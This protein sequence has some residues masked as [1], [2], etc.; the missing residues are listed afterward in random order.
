MVIES[1]LISSL[2]V[3]HGKEG[4]LVN[5]AIRVVV[6]NGV[7]GAIRLARVIDEARGTAHMHAVD[8]VRWRGVGGIHPELFA[9]VILRDLEFATVDLLLQPFAFV[10]IRVEKLGFGD[11]FARI[12]EFIEAKHVVVT[13]A[14]T[15][16]SATIGFVVRNNLTSIRIDERTFQEIDWTAQT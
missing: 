3:L 1:E 7:D 2:D 4:E 6:G 8:G 10:G 13:N 12:A 11:R 16:A 14:L 9:C 15:D 5:I